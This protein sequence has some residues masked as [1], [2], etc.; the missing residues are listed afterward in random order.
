MEVMNIRFS[1]QVGGEEIQYKFN[2]PLIKAT[3]NDDVIYIDLSSIEA[4]RDYDTTFPVLNVKRVDD[5]LSV[6]LYQGVDGQYAETEGWVKADETAFEVSGQVVKPS[7]IEP[8][9]DH[10]KMS[11]SDQIDRLSQAVEDMIL[12][13]MEGG[14]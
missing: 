3:V 10:E 5:E 13:T 1:P 14:E 12:M 6:V 8:I 7:L 4:D 9:T 11:L 2:G